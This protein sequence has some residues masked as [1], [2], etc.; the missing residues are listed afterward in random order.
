MFHSLISNHILG[1]CILNNEKNTL[2]LRFI[3][4]N[5]YHCMITI[6]SESTTF[7]RY[8]PF[9]S[10]HRQRIWLLK[11]NKLRISRFWRF[12][13]FSSMFNIFSIGLDEVIL[14]SIRDVIWICEWSSNQSNFFEGQ[15]HVFLK[16]SC[17]L[18]K[19]GCQQRT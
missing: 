8:F 16:A 7:Y 11:S 9:N 13:R 17:H 12:I 2:K 14:H 19:Q 5:V 10:S 4:F 6:W 1:K 3:T 18:E 15:C